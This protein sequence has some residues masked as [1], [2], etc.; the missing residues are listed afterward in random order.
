MADKICILGGPI[1]K[2]NSKFL[3]AAMTLSS[4]L[5]MIAMAEAEAVIEMEEVVVYGY[6]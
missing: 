5:P 1:V 4:G 3:I 6:P 2:K